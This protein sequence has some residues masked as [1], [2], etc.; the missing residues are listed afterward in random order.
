MKSQRNSFEYM[1]HIALLFPTIVIL[2][3]AFAPSLLFAKASSSD[4][5]TDELA[6]Q[7][8][9]L[10]LGLNGYLIGTTLTEEQKKTA[11]KHPVAKAYE[12]T[13]KFQDDDV[14]VVVSKKTDMILAV[15]QRQE[16]GTREDMRKMVGRLMLEFGEPT[17]MAHD[18][19]IYWAYNK[20]GKISQELYNSAKQSGQLNIL[21]TVKFKSN[22]TSLADVPEDKTTATLYVIITSEPLVQRFMSKAE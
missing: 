1:R 19:I 22:I 14:F 20:D 2:I 13:Y 3:L 11:K 18:Q 15:Y 21:A 10:K 5:S 17:T 4:Q 16:N 6:A 7:V 8:A 12:G 9:N